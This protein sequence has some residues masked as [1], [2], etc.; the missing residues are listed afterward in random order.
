MA[1]PNTQDFNA[2]DNSLLNYQQTNC[3]C[4]SFLEDSPRSY[5]NSKDVLTWLAC[6][7][8]QESRTLHQAP[9]RDVSTGEKKTYFVSPKQFEFLFAKWP[10]M[11][12]T[13]VKVCF[14]GND[15]F[16]TVVVH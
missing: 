5:E 1:H 2:R 12:V 10:F 8:P 16:S 7:A 14:V 11:L 9:E 15:A 4:S 6:D 3:T 13:P